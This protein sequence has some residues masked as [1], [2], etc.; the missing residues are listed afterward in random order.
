M[1]LGADILLLDEPTNHLD[2]ANVAWL[3]RWLVTQRDV[4]VMTVSHD[5]GFLDR[6]CTGEGELRPVCSACGVATTGQ[7]HGQSREP[8]R[9]QGLKGYGASRRARAAPAVM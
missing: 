8:G 3:E 6:V 5:S 1:L 7:D 9:A 4:T 2:T